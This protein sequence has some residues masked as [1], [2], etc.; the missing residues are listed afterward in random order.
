MAITLKKGQKLSLVKELG[1]TSAKIC[2]GW[3]VNQYDT[4]GRYDLDSSVFM[5]N[6]EGKV[7]TDNEFIYYNQ[8]KHPSGAVVHHGDNTKG[9]TKAGEPAEII[10]IDL[11]KV[12]DNIEKIVIV[13]TIYD[14]EGK[15]NFGQVS[16]SFLDLYNIDTDEKVF[17]L[18]LCEDYDLETALIAGEFYRHNGDWKFNPVKKGFNGGLA[19]LCDLYEVD[20]EKQ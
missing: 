5:L 16:D 6:A 1:L 2:L 14:E 19:A 4:G 9:T 13:I 17:H 7:P 11:N 18:D 20:V 12:P 10:D 3:L 8:P 15:L